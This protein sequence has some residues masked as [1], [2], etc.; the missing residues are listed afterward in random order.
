MLKQ[1]LQK[2]CLIPYLTYADPD[3]ETFEQL[4]RTALENGAGVLEIGLPF[5]DPI[6]DGPVIQASHQRA[7]KHHPKL[8]DIFACVSRL[9]ADYETPIVLM[10]ALNL[11]EHFGVEAFF[12]SAQRAGVDGVILPDLLF[13]E[14]GPYKRI[15]RTHNVPI[16]T[17]MSHLCDP[18]RRRLMVQDCD[19]FLYLMA[20]LGIT[21]E[22]GFES[23]GILEV[24]QEI[25]AIRDIPV[26]IGFGISHPDHV[27]SVFS[28]ADGAIVGSYLVRLLAASDDP[29]ATLKKEL[30]FLLQGR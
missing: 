5:S 28:G 8:T 16:I 7:L 29:V 9:K 18:E 24:V 1:A 27:K 12:E 10:G 19:G 30:Q 15:A 6:A 23:S 22:S 3:P 2:N 21:G 17:L 26:S 14:M 20:R 11:V 25:K 4:A 13:E